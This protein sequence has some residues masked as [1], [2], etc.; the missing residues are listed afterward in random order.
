MNK[1]LN[2]RYC[3]MKDECLQAVHDDDLLSLLKS[4]G[5]EKN[6][7]SGECVC[8]VCGKI[9]TLENLG[10]IVPQDGNI[11]FVCDD[12]NCINAMAKEGDA[13]ESK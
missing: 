3:I 7:L 10:A 6:I 8:N 1:N 2:K 11:T 5:V 12:L 4:L 13:G 9:I